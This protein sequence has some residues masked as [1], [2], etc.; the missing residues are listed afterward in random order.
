MKFCTSKYCH[1]ILEPQPDSEFYEGFAKCKTCVRKRQLRYRHSPKGEA[2][3]I[4]HRQS[5]KG[6][7]GNKQMVVRY[8]STRKGKVSTMRAAAMRTVNRETLQIGLAFPE[9]KYCCEFTGSTA[10]CAVALGA[11]SLTECQVFQEW[12]RTKVHPLS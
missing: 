7:L 3:H 12:K 5:Q 8:Q 10:N 1:S 11:E 6:L 9:C 4:K 2:A